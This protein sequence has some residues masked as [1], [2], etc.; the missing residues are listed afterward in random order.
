VSVV[1]YMCQSRLDMPM[2]MSEQ[3]TDIYVQCVLVLSEQTP[4]VY[5]HCVLV[6]S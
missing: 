6:V 4:D 2:P 3:T 5:V 1:G